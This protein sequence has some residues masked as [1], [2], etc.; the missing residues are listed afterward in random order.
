MEKSFQ[1]RRRG[2]YTTKNMEVS[3]KILEGDFLVHKHGEILSQ[4]EKLEKLVSAFYHHFN[5]SVVKLRK[6]MSLL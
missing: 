1:Q 3:F 2:N 4:R 6:E 5:F